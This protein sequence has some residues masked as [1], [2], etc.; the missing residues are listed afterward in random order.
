MFSAC[1]GLHSSI[2]CYFKPLGNLSYTHN[3][4]IYKTGG[5]QIYGE[6]DFASPKQNLE[7]EEQ[8]TTEHPGVCRKG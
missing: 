4:C 1:A 3:P 5:N 2:L 6:F 8:K 7:W